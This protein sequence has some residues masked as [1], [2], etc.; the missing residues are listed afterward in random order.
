MRTKAWIDR[1]RAE[2]QSAALTDARALVLEL[3]GFAPVTPYDAMRAGV[4]LEAGETAY[5]SVACWVQQQFPGGWSQPIWSQVLVTDRRL[6]IRVGVGGAL[7]SL[8]WSTLVGLHVDLESERI[9]LD[10]GDGSPR[11]LTGPAA[12]IIAVAGI[13]KVYGVDALLTHPALRP[14]RTAAEPQCP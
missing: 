8:W 9:V 10:Y 4:V 1:Q 12:P 13:A 7:I 3:A 11:L 14:I 6:L 2:V 5:R